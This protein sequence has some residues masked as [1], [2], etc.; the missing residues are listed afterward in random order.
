VFLRNVSN[1]MAEHVTLQ[2]RTPKLWCSAASGLY[3]SCRV[4]L[5]RTL[6]I[7]FVISGCELGSNSVQTS[8]PIR[9]KSCILDTP[10]Y[11]IYQFSIL[12]IN[13]K[14]PPTFGRHVKIVPPLNKLNTKMY[15]GQDIKL[16]VLLTLTF[17]LKNK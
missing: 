12:L 16:S 2:P 13:F 11:F 6:L 7:S 17:C 8:R 1:H 14:I 9:W 15:R 10:Q 4:L 3:T 5:R